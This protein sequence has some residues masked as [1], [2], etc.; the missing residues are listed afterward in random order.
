VRADIVRCAKIMEGF[1]DIGAR[2]VG[3]D[4]PI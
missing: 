3:L 1:Y 2:F 4:V